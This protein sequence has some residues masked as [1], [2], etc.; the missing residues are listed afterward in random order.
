MRDA[1]D[2]IIWWLI[3]HLNLHG[4][5]SDAGDTIIYEIFVRCYLIW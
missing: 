5:D 3:R 4:E 1:T 2:L